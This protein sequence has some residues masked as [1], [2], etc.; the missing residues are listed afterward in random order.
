MWVNTRE[1]SREAEH[2]RKHGF[3]I[4]APPGSK[5]HY[6]YWSEQLRRCIE[7]Y[8]V[9]GMKIT[10]D[11]YNY[12]NFTKIK[13]TRGKKK[14]QNKKADFPSF[15]DGDY[16]FFWAKNI[17]AYGMPESEY[18]NLNLV[19]HPT[20]L[21]GGHHLVITKARRKG[22]SYKIASIAANTYNTVRNSRTLLCAYDSVYLYPDGTMTKTLDNLNFFNE[23]TG[24]AKR[25][26]AVNQSKHVRAS[27]YEY[28]GNGEKI[29]K[30]YKSEIQAL[31]FQNADDKG[32]GKDPTLIIFEEAGAFDN[33]KTSLLAMLP[34]VQDGDIV[35][36][37]VIAF[38]T[39]GD[40]DGGTI[41]LENIFYD[42]DTY[43]FLPFE[44]EW[45]D[46]G[47]ICGLFF[48]S[49]MNKVGFMDEDGNSRIEEA[50][51]YEDAQREKLAKNAKDINALDSFMTENPQK[52]SEAFLQTGNNIFP[53]GL[54]K[55]WEAQ[56]KTNPSYR[57]LG[58][59]GKLNEH[60]GK[61]RFKPDDSVRPVTEFPLR[62]G[63][64]TTGC[65][66]VF[67]APYK[68]HEGL[69]PDNL[70]TIWVDP[71]ALDG[72]D[73]KSLG[74]AYVYKRVNRMSLPDDLI[75]ASYI[76]RPESQDEFNRILFLLAKFYNARIGF[77]NDRGDTIGYAKRTNNLYWLLGEVEI[78]DKSENIN[79]RRLGRK[80]GTSMG[81]VQRKDQAMIYLRDWL[82]TPR[83]KD[84]NGTPIYNLH[85]IYDIGLLREL[86]KYGKGNFDRVSACLVGMFYM[87]DLHNREV[88][89]PVSEAT[90]TFWEREFFA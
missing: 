36:G 29:E 90:E 37:Q 34:S 77:E 48:P 57:N 22:F 5:L 70:Y 56:L 19:W 67:Q 2:F 42:P 43:N 89:E 35:T 10:G 47:G 74:V 46:G 45:D 68:N 50:I 15:W 17:A 3:Y 59:H 86:I 87:K 21:D 39:G 49:Y 76:A 24:W 6:D 26:Q 88:E 53:Q 55:E 44:N 66:T 58:V 71:Y 80:F 1:F 12:L 82:K 52:P 65:V 25:R 61:V 14:R 16:N 4:D 69:I 79:I 75:V 27:F 28:D 9:G 62:S 81:S 41:D 7:G 78:L 64:D 8:S 32:R 31:S 30:G 84:K 33:F 38:G 63:T 13:R 54:L 73:G 60:G 18:K 40:M 85:F 83:G 51:A 23:H 20:K 11:H 72:G